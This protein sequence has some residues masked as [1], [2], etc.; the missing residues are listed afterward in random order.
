MP[1][2]EWGLITLGEVNSP[3]DAPVRIRP[4]ISAVPAYR[5]GQAPA[6]GGFKLSS[7]ENPFPT[8]PAILDRIAEAREVNRYGKAALLP[9][10]SRLAETHGVDVDE[11]HVGSGSVGLLYQLIHAVAGPGEEYLSAWP[12]FEAYPLLGLAS[13]ARHVGVPG[14][15]DGRHDLTAMAAAI[16]ERT[17]AVLL[18][19]PNNPTGPALG[20]AETIA[21]LEQI[22]N[23]VLVILDEAYAEFVRDED[24]VRG[25]DLLTRFPQVVSL[26]TFSKAAGLADLRIG[27]AIGNATI[28]NAAR[29]IA[30][31]LSV[32]AASEAGAVAA[33]GLSRELVERID[34]LVERRTALRTGLISQGYRVPDAQGNFVWLPVGEAAAELGAR[35]LDAGILIRPFP[36]LGVRIS[37]GEPESIPAVLAVTAAFAADRPDLMEGR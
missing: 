7:N 28:L 17:R 23:D 33:L 24:A 37:V 27:Y 30:T 19:T 1:R 10:R 21:F 36:G 4:E 20:R 16:T 35:C 18:C 15:A 11:V 29:V 25:A 8:L 32:S 34:T 6:E 31:P 13:G 3:S 26:R 5:Q 9:L 2:S 14:T 22:P 12:S